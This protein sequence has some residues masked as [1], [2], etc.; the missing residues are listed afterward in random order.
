MTHLNINPK[1]I[2]N[3]VNGSSAMDKSIEQAIIYQMGREGEHK[4]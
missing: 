1:E 2:L 3:N 4:S